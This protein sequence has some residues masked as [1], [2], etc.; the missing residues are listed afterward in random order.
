MY[1]VKLIENNLKLVNNSLE[2]NEVL[3][4]VRNSLYAIDPSLLE[5][6]NAIK[7]LSNSNYNSFY[8]TQQIE[9]ID[10]SE[11][12]NHVFFDS[13]VN[14]VNFVLNKI[15]NFPYDKGEVEYN[16]FI[17]SLEGY[18]NY[19][20]KNLFPKYKGMLKFSGNE[21]LMIKNQTGSFLERKNN[22]KI[23][24]LMPSKRFSFNFWLK[25]DSEGFQNNQ[26]VFKLFNNNSASGL[27]CFV[28]E[29]NSQYYL[30]FLIINKNK[31]L[32]KKIKVVL[33][34]FENITINVT[35]EN[36]KKNISFLVNGN[37][38]NASQA[39]V[40][41]LPDEEFDASLSTVDTRL[42]LGGSENLSVNTDQEYIFTNFKGSLDDFRYF[43][44]INFLI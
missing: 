21:K 30:N 26:V 17:D 6:T 11:F 8:A 32:S 22:D 40:E 31:Y 19:V 34:T 27:I 2:E 29:V 4:E 14:K 41:V 15:L 10:Y 35:S 43:N 7:M 1:D 37:R 9:S 24:Q 23:G 3:S 12:K 28:E 39:S 36:N 42:V 20:Y 5:K 18:M 33:D 38:V 13:A 16:N 25:I 44:K